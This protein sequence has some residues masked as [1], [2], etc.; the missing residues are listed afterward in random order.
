[1]EELDFK[2]NIKI[3]PKEKHTRQ[4]QC[5]SIEDYF[6]GSQIEF[7]AAVAFLVGCPLQK[8]QPT[9]FESVQPALLIV[10]QLLEYGIDP[11]RVISL[12]FH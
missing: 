8:S 10:Q 3:T 7:A 4:H 1:M 11:E 6:S 12:I 5:D 2:T 9:A